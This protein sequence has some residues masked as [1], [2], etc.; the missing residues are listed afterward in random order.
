M[1]S[2]IIENRNQFSKTYS[3]GGGKFNKEMYAYPIHYLDDNG[4]WED[5][6]T[7]IAG[8]NDWEF[9]EGVT[10]N[11]FRTYF[12]DVS[13]VNAHLLGV[14]FK[15]ETDRWINLKLKEAKPTNQSYK[16]NVYKFHECFENIDVEYI[17]LP[18]SVKENIILN[19]PTDIRKFEF[20]VKAGGTLLKKVGESICIIDANNGDSLWVL[21]DPYMID[22]LGAVSQGVRYDIDSVDEIQILNV[23]ILDDAFLENASYPVIIDPTIIA[24]QVSPDVVLATY[25]TESYGSNPS[26]WAYNTST[27]F[28]GWM[29]GW[30]QNVSAIYFKAYDSLKEALSLSKEMV[31]NKSILSLGIYRSG[32]QVAQG[33]SM[34]DVAAPMKVG[35]I[36]I[37]AG[38]S[39]FTGGSYPLGSMIDIDV[40]DHITSKG[41]S[42]NGFYFRASAG[43]TGTGFYSPFYSDVTKRPKFSVEYMFKPVLAFHD[44]TIDTNSGGYYSDSSGDVFKYLQFEPMTAGQTSLVKKAYIRN[45]SGFDVNGL[46]VSI[47][48][49]EMPSGMYV[50][51]S[52]SNNPFIENQM[53]EF[54]GITLNNQDRSFFVRIRTDDSV[55]SGS[56]FNIYTKAYPAL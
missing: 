34:F 36:P 5:I 50:R 4:D 43:N 42:F 7:T 16:E 25:M 46:K 6:N 15:G 22:S 8:F 23:T 45:L 49:F 10:T 30:E 29:F 17:I 37:L 24:S 33:F 31:I 21:D 48:D 26:G 19:E 40:T 2:E 51:L 35:T 55:K 13:D 1:A 28:G 9:S 32:P 54:N 27:Y 39:Y 18:E 47:N 52:E 20:T 38:T 41:S 3:L 11:I 56:E 14:E 12:G 53:I 44:G